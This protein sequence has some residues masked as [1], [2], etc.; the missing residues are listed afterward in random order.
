[1]EAPQDKPAYIAGIRS[2]D[3]ITAI[4]GQ[5]IS[6]W[7]DGITIINNSAGKEITSALPAITRFANLRPAVAFLKK[8]SQ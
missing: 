5:K 6:D 3:I 2:G 1:M 7:S 8:T 4:D